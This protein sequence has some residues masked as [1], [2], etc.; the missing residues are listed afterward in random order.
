MSP[1]A[2]ARKDTQLY[3]FHSMYSTELTD[4]CATAYISMELSKKLHVGHRRKF[5]KGEGGRESRGQFHNFP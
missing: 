4:H 5:W 1:Y 2:V 3:Y